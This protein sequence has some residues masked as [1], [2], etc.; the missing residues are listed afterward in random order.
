MRAS[1][2]AS[3]KLCLSAGYYQTAGSTKPNYLS[4]AAGEPSDTESVS[5]VMLETGQA[6]GLE[7]TL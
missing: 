3:P 1:P 4:G 6:S 7:D 5:K 2:V